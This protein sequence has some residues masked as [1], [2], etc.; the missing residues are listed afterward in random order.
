MPAASIEERIER[1]DSFFRDDYLW[2]ATVEYEAVLRDHPDHLP[3][4]RGLVKVYGRYFRHTGWLNRLTS[5]RDL[6][7]ALS[8]S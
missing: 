5:V 2:N 3:A 8:L 7:R 1:A 4:L 6:Y